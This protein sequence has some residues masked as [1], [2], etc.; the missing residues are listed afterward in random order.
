MSILGNT[1]FGNHFGIDLAGDGV[2]PN[3]V[4]D[5]DAG[6]NSLQNFPEFTSASFTGSTLTVVYSVPSTTTNSA[7]PLRIEFFKA[8]PATAQ[9]KTFLGF[10]VYT[11][12]DAGKPKTASITP[13]AGITLRTGDR[14]VAT[15]SDSK[16]NTSEFSAAIDIAVKLPVGLDFG[17]APNSY[18]TLLASDGPRHSLGA[19]PVLGKAI[20]ADADG[21]P[22]S[23]AAGDSGDDGV[24]LPTRLIAGLDAVATVIASRPA[25]STPGSTSTE[26]AFSTPMNKLPPACRL[27]REQTQS[28]LP[29][30]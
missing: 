7:Y 30:R 24:T 6:P 4:G 14:L 19:G 23:T 25:D 18:H 1:I 11:A 8:D 26:T 29:Y 15:A 22:S 20:T 10:D 2:T 3:D 16:G 21:K 13:P 9:G 17:D 5:A 12:N 27:S 28:S